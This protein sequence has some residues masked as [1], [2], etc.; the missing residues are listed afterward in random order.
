MVIKILGEPGTA[1]YKAAA[2]VVKRLGHAVYDSTYFYCDLS[3]APLL[4]KKIS[5]FEL[6]E[7]IHG[8]LIFHPSPL[9]HGRGASSIRWAYRRKEVIT[10]ATWF[11]AN[12]R[13]DGGDICEAEIIK[14]DYSLSPKEFYESHIIPALERTLQRSLNAISSGFIRR[15]PQIDEYSSYD[16]KL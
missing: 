16:S 11:W 4:T 9:P 7:P 5:D 2:A 13:L 10:A 14:V 8:T 6:M 15:V 1:A 12:N 3:I